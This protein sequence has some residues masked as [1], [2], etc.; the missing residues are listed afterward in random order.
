MPKIPE[1]PRNPGQGDGEFEGRRY[2]DHGKW[3]H[4]SRASPDPQN[5]NENVD[6]CLEKRI[7][8]KAVATVSPDRLRCQ[9]PQPP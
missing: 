8:A 2:T 1:I 9:Q 6:N 3:E 7:D 4:E 5:T